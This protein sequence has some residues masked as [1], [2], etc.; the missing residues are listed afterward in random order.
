MWHGAFTEEDGFKPAVRTGEQGGRRATWLART[1]R[2][3]V[4]VIVTGSNNYG[5][6]NTGRSY[7]GVDHQRDR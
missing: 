7:P 1:R 4:A 6:S 3:W 2:V 5:P